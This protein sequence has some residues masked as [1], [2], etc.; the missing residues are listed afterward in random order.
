MVIY[1]CVVQISQLL[2][3]VEELDISS[4]ALEGTEEPEIVKLRGDIEC[5]L[6]VLQERL[7]SVDKDTES[8]ACLSG[9][10]EDMTEV[11]T[12]VVNL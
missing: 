5:L 11:H 1:F 7:R 12:T 4:G 3:H 6:P 10:R 9:F 2:D 8:V